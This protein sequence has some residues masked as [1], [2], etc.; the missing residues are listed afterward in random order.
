MGPH[1]KEQSF[2]FYT[3]LGVPF[4]SQKAQCL[5]GAKGFYSPALDFVIL[6]NLVSTSTK[7][8]LGFIG[9]RMI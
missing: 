3:A 4:F 9:F 8:G 1:N 2:R 5:L 7:K 6:C